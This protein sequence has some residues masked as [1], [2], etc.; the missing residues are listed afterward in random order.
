MMKSYREDDESYFE[1]NPQQDL[2]LNIKPK[3]PMYI[4]LGENTDKKTKPNTITKTQKEKTEEY[5]IKNEIPGLNNK[6]IFFL[7][8]LMILIIIT[9]L[10]LNKMIYNQKVFWV[11]RKTEEEKKDEK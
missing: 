8:L 5:E 2:Y 7:F 6:N 10:I 9:K 11:K 3:L 4:L 1:K